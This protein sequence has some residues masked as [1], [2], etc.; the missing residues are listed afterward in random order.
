MLT[1]SLG[2]IRAHGMIQ[3]DGH[4]SKSTYCD[5]SFLRIFLDG[6]HGQRT[7]HARRYHIQ[8]PCQAVQYLGIPCG[9]GRSSKTHNLPTRGD[10]ATGKVYSMTILMLD[11][12]TMNKSTHR[13]QPISP[14]MGGTNGRP[15]GPLGLLLRFLILQPYIQLGKAQP[16][17]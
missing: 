8:I 16:G 9:R 12:S 5:C 2:M 11:V 10:P 6:V 15:P 4:R 3:V 17:G 1:R 7:F 13:G 14:N